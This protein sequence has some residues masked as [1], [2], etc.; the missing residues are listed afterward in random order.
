MTF[1]GYKG[2]DPSKKQGHK[3]STGWHLQQWFPSEAHL[4]SP[5]LL[6]LIARFSAQIFSSLR[7]VKLLGAYHIQP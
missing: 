1:K 7:E 3:N 2:A 6:R 4:G 5:S